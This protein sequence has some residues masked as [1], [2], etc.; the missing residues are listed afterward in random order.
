MN[1]CAAFIL[2]TVVYLMQ[3]AGAEVTLP[4]SPPGS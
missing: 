2:V 4:M 1:G 3:N